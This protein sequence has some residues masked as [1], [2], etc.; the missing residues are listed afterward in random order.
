[1]LSRARVLV[2]L[3]RRANNPPKQ[4]EIEASFQARR[5]KY[6]A[7]RGAIL[8]TQART[9]ITHSAHA[10]THNLPTHPSLEF[11]YAVFSRTVSLTIS[12]T[13]RRTIP[14]RRF[15]VR[16]GRQGHGSIHADH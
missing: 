11:T 10:P 1:L 5:H 13:T 12:F 4:E 7:R 3:V 2:A 6:G 8:Q 16:Y 14:A 15:A 9:A